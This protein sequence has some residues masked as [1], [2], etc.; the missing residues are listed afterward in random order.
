MSFSKVG[1]AEAFMQCASFFMKKVNTV[2]FMLGL[3]SWG[4][5]V[6]VGADECRA[7]DY[8]DQEY[9]YFDESGTRV[10]SKAP[11]LA[12]G[13]EL[14]GTFDVSLG[15]GTVDEYD[16]VG[17]DPEREVIISVEVKF[18]L[19][20][21]SIEVNLGGSELTGSMRSSD[22]GDGGLKREYYVYEYD[23]FGVEDSVLIML[24]KTGKVSW[25]LKSNGAGSGGALFGALLEVKTRP[26]LNRDEAIA[27]DRPFIPTNPTDPTNS[28]DPTNPTNPM[29]PVDPTEGFDPFDPE[30]PLV[31]L[32]PKLP[33]HPFV[34]EKP[35]ILFSP[36]N[37]PVPTSI[38]DSG[39][40][41]LLL[42]FG[43]L[44]VVGLKRL[45][46]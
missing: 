36:T 13:Q 20:S 3:L 31:P 2:R 39:T 30:N 18:W 6:A 8:V 12:D 1:T 24:S 15:S 46:N 37:A 4:L 19:D 27:E 34:P 21:N 29:D 25:K 11:V 16:R 41:L 9:F 35:I 22:P 14:N 7:A 38:P 5:L 17:Y 23:H 33:D 10:F 26:R 40:T 44:G 43:F 32:T 45:L 42:V 28:T